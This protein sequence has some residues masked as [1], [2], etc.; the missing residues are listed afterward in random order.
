VIVKDGSLSPVGDNIKAVVEIKLGNQG[1]GD[2]Q[3]DAYDTI[4]GGP[5]NVLE[6]NESNCDC[7]DEKTPAPPPV[8]AFDKVKENKPSYSSDQSRSLA[9]A[10]AAVAVVG[11][12]VAVAAAIAAAPVTATAAAAVAVFSLFGASQAGNTGSGGPDVI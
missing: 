5:D 3:R 4:A 2:G 7:G 8:P 6:M 12:V 11:C 1:W 10:L 9:P